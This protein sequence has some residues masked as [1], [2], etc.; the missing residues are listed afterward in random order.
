[1]ANSLLAFLYLRIKGSQEDVA[2]YSLNYIL[3]KSEVL[4]SEFTRLISQ[5]LHLDYQPLIYSAQVI[6]SQ[7]ERPD[8]VGVKDEQEEII[9]EAKFFAALT[10]NQPGT[11]L[12]RLQGRG[13]LIFICP[14][15]RL[16]GLW[17]HLQELEKTSEPLGEYCV[18]R[19]GTHMAIIS[20]KTVF[21]AL[22]LCS[23]NNAIDTKEDLHQLIGFCKEIESNDFIPFK[24]EDL[25]ADMAKSMDRYYIL[26]GIG[27]G[28]YFHRGIW[29]KSTPPSPFCLGFFTDEALVK[30]YLCSLESRMVERDNNGFSYIVLTP[31]IALTREESAQYLAD[32][33]VYHVRKINE[34]R[35]KQEL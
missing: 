33:I 7:K 18:N 8:I 23:E 14:E 20:W 11:Y 21:E 35:G 29:K 1:M 31:P 17:A 28:L 5:R 26:D 10:E 32:Q 12:D 25:G 34:K 13:G 3:G 9:I 22:Q 15:S 4:R 19:N 27:L 24:A 30:N 6:G 16:N 2:T